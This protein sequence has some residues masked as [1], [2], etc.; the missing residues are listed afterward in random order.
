MKPKSRA[1]PPVMHA[2]VNCPGRLAHLSHTLL[3]SQGTPGPAPGSQS[4]RSEDGN[5]KANAPLSSERG[6]W[7]HAPPDLRTLQPDV[8]AF[9]SSLAKSSQAEQVL[10][11]F[12]SNI[13]N[14]LCFQGPLGRLCHSST[15]KEEICL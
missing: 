12:Q 7:S 6:S 2:V 14:P 5:N 13:P 11:Q 3:T 8:G 15:G 1:S 9:L 10:C 4:G